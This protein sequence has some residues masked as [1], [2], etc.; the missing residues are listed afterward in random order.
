MA[1]FIDKVTE[2]ELIQILD[3]MSDQFHKANGRSV[4][5]FADRYHYSGSKS[6]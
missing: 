2:K 3:S 5:A 4:L 6:S 1:D